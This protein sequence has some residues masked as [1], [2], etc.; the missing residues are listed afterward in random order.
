MLPLGK[1]W[2]ARITHEKNITFVCNLFI[3]IITFAQRQRHNLT[4]KLTRAY[5]HST[6]CQNLHPPSIYRKSKGKCPTLSCKS[7]K[8]S[9]LPSN[10]PKID[11]LTVKFLYPENL[12][13]STS[14][15]N[16]FKQSP[17]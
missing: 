12:N 1:L 7:Y 15:H 5:S 10:V 8:L 14:P 4:S 9:I 3:G 17:R 16:Y 6:E 2:R 11:S 13:L